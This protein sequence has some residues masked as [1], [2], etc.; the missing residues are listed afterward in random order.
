M[1]AE[2]PTRDDPHAVTGVVQGRVQGVGFRF[3]MQ[4]EAQRLGVTGWVRNLPDRCVA[5]HAEGPAD[6]VASLVRWAGSG[7]PLA[8]V[9]AV[10]VTPG[11]VA[12]V[13]TFEILR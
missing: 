1:P 6:A 5:F 10:K 2:P 8:R 11:R 7:P 13:G 3:S 4:Q 12:Q 9:D